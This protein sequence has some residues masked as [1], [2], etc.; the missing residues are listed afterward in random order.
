M[1]PERANTDLDAIIVGSCPNGYNSDKQVLK[2]IY[3]I[4]ITL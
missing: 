1:K 2:D 4:K 3:N